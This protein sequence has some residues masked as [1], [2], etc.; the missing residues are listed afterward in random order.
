V[1]KATFHFALVVCGLAVLLALPILDFGAISTRNQV[2]RLERGTV[3]VDQF[4]FAALRWDFGEPG[5]R[6]LR[7][8]AK[9]GNAQIAELAQTALAQASRTYAGYE[10]TVRTDKDF[11]LR[12]QPDD[13]ALRALVLEYLKANPWRCQAFCVAVE[14]GKAVGSVRRVALVEGSGYEVVPLADGRP[15]ATPSPAPVSQGPTLTEKSTVELRAWSGRQ[16]YVDGKPVGAPL[17]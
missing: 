17:D 14:L 16:I 8:L 11:K 5:R 15:I 9:S 10:D 13:P 12:V 2:A 7:R 6:A 4:D 1:R 3:P